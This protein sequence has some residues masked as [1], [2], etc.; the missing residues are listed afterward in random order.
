MPIL[1]VYWVGDLP[2]DADALVQSLANAAGDALNAAPGRV[3]MRLHSLP[4]DHYAENGGPVVGALPLFVRILH[5]HPA[6]RRRT[7]G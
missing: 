1:D 6:D 5:A 7:A 3:W 2:A 4:A